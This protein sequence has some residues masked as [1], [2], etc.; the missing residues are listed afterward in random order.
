MPKT[1]RSLFGV[2]LLCGAGITAQ[3][4]N[5]VTFQVD[6]TQQPGASDVFVRGGFNGWGLA[7]QLTNDS[8]G[9]YTGTVDIADA[10]GTVEQYKFYFDP[11]AVWESPASTCGNNRTF[12]LAGGA[13]TLPVVYWD[14]APPVLPNNDVTFQVD[15]S[16]QVATGAFTNGVSTVTVSGGFTGWG[17][18][19]ALTNDPSLLGNASNIYS[20]VITVPGVVGA[21]QSYKFRNLYGWESPAS[22]GGG[23]RTFQIAGGNQVLPLV[24]YNDASSC[25]V[26]LAPTDVTFV[27]RMTN[28]TPS[29]DGGIIFNSAVNKLHLNG[30]FLGW[31]AW[32]DG[33]SGG[34]GPANELTNNPVGSDYYQ[35]TFTIPA[36]TSLNQ[37]YKYSI[38]GYDNEAG[39]AV[40]HSRY[41][42]TLSGVAYTMPVDRFGTNPAPSTAEAS[43]GSLAVSAPSGG[44][45]PVTWSGR[46][47]VTL[48]TKDTING[49][50]Q[51]L[52][53]TEGTSATNWPNTGGARF[54]RLQKTP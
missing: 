44:N 23:N 7:N 18:G 25:D 6:M 34:N 54:F 19:I 13:Q 21:C 29:A 53:A 28:G 20:M 41:V 51:N 15:M 27:L 22:T 38:D 16:V 4:Q 37:T 33:I 1:L 47:C 8:T 30:E 2:G 26:L 48:Q 9:V 39:F 45:I 49:A 50:W 17:D 10:P 31:W 46:Q 3:A 5:P 32:Y 24:Y 40:N 12:T 11:G 52:S 43:F 35:Q 42:R 14:D 36:G